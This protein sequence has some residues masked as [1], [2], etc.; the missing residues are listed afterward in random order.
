MQKLRI[1]FKVLAIL[2][3]GFFISCGKPAHDIDPLSIDFNPTVGPENWVKVTAGQ[4]ISGLNE[5]VKKIDYDFEIMATEVT[6]EQYAGFL[7]EALAAGKIEIKDGD[8]FGFYAGDEFHNGRHEIPIKAGSYKYYSLKGIKSRIV[9]GNG[10]FGVK[11]GYGDFPAAYVS[12]MGARAYTRFYGYRLPSSLEWEKAARGTDGRSFPFGE[13]PTPQRANYY[14]S[15]DPF[16]VANGTTPVG[17]YNGGMHG[18]FK[19][20]DSPSPYGCYDMAG[21][22]AEWMEDIHHGSHLR[23]IYGGSM[24]DYDYNL[25]SFTENSAMPDYTS[26]QVGF[27]C[28]RDIKMANK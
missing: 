25:R 16:D 28:V 11:N 22:V 14:H 9:F 27:R 23:L 3:F 7:N 13:E 26:F 6:F 24:M 12:W 10:R 18:G 19:T 20:E 15:K 2:G 1:G 21:N 8:V 5:K 17:F 4:F